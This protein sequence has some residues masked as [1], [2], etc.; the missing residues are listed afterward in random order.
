MDTLAKSRYKMCGSAQHITSMIVV[1]ELVPKWI[2]PK[3][4]NFGIDYI[5]NI[6]V[7]TSMLL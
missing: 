2:R 6:S 1:R 7:V 5:N 4:N 3:C